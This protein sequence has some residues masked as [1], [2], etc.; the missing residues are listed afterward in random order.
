MKYTIAKV[1]LAATVS[2]AAL[3]AQ[4]QTTL[5]GND[6]GPN[7]GVRSKA[8][9]FV[10]DE[11]ER[12]TNGAVKVEQNWGG[13]LFKT[14]A[15]LSSMS[16]GVADM[17]LI[18]GTYVA[19]EFPELNLLGLPLQDAHPWVTMNAVY[20]MF[21]TNE[22]IKQRLDELNL[23]YTASYAL[24][25]VIL[26]CRGDGIRSI[27]DIDG[28]KI[29]R[30]SVVADT[31]GELGANI[32][33]MPIYETYQGVETGLIDCAFTYSYYAVST[34]LYEEIDTITLLDFATITSLGNFI[35]K[36]SFDRLTPEQQD[37]I[38]SIGP[39]LADYYA[40]E[41]IAADD[42]AMA[43]MTNAE[44][45]VEVV[46]LSD[47]GYAQ[48]AAATKPTI[49]KWKADA[50][51]AGLDAE[52]LLAEYTSLIAKWTAKLEAEGMPKQAN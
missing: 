44:K 18:I 2:M 9:N 23:V 27:K 4:A 20:E 11:I 21:T 47:E 14:N 46:R 32:V 3:A 12:R 26:A 15:A 16:N 24:T 17:G 13:A 22:Q 28:A 50:T 51:N 25:P 34:K 35:N 48:L 38:L 40:G 31:F 8:V 30:S 43:V 36:D 45:P 41:L 42:E 5:I 37:A 7:R 1:A 29:A 10:N 6:P 39:D 52:A 19:S 33:D 49:D